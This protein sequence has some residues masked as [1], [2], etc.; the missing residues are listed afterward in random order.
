MDTWTADAQARRRL[1]IKGSAGP[2]RRSVRYR[3]LSTMLVAD[4]IYRTPEPL[5]RRR[6]GTATL[7]LTDGTDIVVRVQEVG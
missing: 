3:Q 1:E 6:F 4:P 2:A 7:P 5:S